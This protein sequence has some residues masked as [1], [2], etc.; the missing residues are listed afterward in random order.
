M[1]KKVEVL[2]PQELRGE[3]KKRITNMFNYYK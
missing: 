1:G 2:K 3:M